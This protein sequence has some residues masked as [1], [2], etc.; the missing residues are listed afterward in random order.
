MLYENCNSFYY[1]LI[2]KGLS[3][4]TWVSRFFQNENWFSKAIFFTNTIAINFKPIFTTHISKLQIIIKKMH[5]GKMG[6]NK[7]KCLYIRNFIS[8]RSSLKL[9]QLFFQICIYPN[10]FYQVLKGF[11]TN[12]M[13]IGPIF[14][15]KK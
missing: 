15:H 3:E 7:C 12:Y 6:K 10:E 9:F 8:I 2:K 4:P 5:V 1:Y 11:T 14:I 13:V